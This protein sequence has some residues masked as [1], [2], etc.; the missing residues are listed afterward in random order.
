MPDNPTRAGRNDDDSSIN[1][2]LKGMEGISHFLGIGIND[3]LFWDKLNNAVRD[4]EAVAELLKKEYGIRNVDLLLKEEATRK[5]ILKKL[6]ALADDI[7]DPDSL[8]IY[9][10]GHGHLHR[11]RGY[12]VPYDDGKHGL[13]GLIPNSEILDHIR[14]IATRHTLVLSDACFSGT[15][16]EATAANRG[17][18]HTIIQLSNLPSRWV[19]CSGR[20]NETVSDGP[21]GGH[22]PF[23]QSI[24]DILGNTEEE[25]ILISELRGKIIKQTK[26][27]YDK[28]QLPNGGRLNFSG[29]SEGEY[30]FVR[31]IDEVSLWEK[32]Q[33][34]NTPAG[35]S[36]YLEIF[37]NGIHSHE[38]KVRLTQLEAENKWQAIQKAPKDTLEQITPLLKQITAYVRDYDS[39][40]NIY[41][42]EAVKLGRLLEDKKDLLQSWDSEFRLLDLLKRETAF[43]KEAENRLT[44]IR[45]KT[46]FHKEPEPIAP[47]QPGSPTPINPRQLTIELLDEDGRLL[48]SPIRC[49]IGSDHY[50]DTNHF[51]YLVPAGEQ[52]I[53]FL[54][55]KQGYLT[56]ETHLDNNVF[57]KG[58][59][60]ATLK[61]L[62]YSCDLRIV[63]YLKLN[64]TTLEKPVAAA[65]VYAT[66]TSK[67]DDDIPNVRN[68]IFQS[69]HQGR[70]K[71]TG[72]YFGDY[73]SITVSKV[74]FVEKEY[75]STRIIQDIKTKK[76]A[77]VPKRKKTGPFIPNS[78]QI[79]AGVGMLFAVIAILSW[80][81]IQRIN[82]LE[83]LKSK[84][85]YEAKIVTDE[86]HY[87]PMVLLDSE[88]D[89]TISA[90]EGQISLHTPLL[91]EFRE[92]LHLYKTTQQ[93]ANG[94]LRKDTLNAIRLRLERAIDKMRLVDFAQTHRQV[95]DDS[96]Q[97]ISRL[98]SDRKKDIDSEAELIMS[99]MEAIVG[100]E[101]QKQAE[102]DRLQK[103]QDDIQALYE[104]RD[105]R[106]K[107]TNAYSKA[108]IVLEANLHLFGDKHNQYLSRLK[109]L[110][111]ARANLYNIQNNKPASKEYTDA[112][113][114]LEMLRASL[115][116][117]KQQKAVIAHIINGN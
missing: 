5:N 75:W 115:H 98:I 33:A 90:L 26:D 73:L 56:F 106:Y 101:D 108:I 13:D 8:I 48:P 46:K 45:E 71:I 7:K 110:R 77:L 76:I 14:A 93:K 37:P 1:Q 116:L 107:P 18:G 64:H 113:N 24:L 83:N 23:A 30:V 78:K 27:D 67:K 32:C 61:K 49:S 109:A 104:I 4:V 50:D 47:G 41:H 88:T 54:V 29:F 114:E 105:W 51:T 68:P 63:H 103:L 15:L 94:T 31:T 2:P 36:R 53:T 34:D 80:I 89:S 59:F 17:S 10:A 28:R 97:Y 52:I 44:E 40:D 19:L 38:A 6:D 12:W 69:D 82:K 100:D 25:Y 62:A 99:K 111:D 84:L 66:I 102:E 55:E 74:S 79:I 86:T 11:G 20:H 92:E 3:Y 91:E 112:I 35:Y 39:P 16:Y 96:K 9:Y 58:S 21:P 85:R 57:S 42:Q 70:V 60:K 65:T 117:S 22:S 72:L 43:R 95:A 87:P 81:V